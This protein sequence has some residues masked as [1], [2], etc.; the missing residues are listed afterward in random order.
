MRR[1]W[2]SGLAAWALAACGA[3]PGTPSADA[4]DKDATAADAA[5]VPDSA[6][7]SAV[8]LVPRAGESRY[9][10]VGEPVV[11]DGSA[12][13]GAVAF[14]WSFGDGG[15]WDAP[16]PEPTA[17]VA[18]DRP[19][20]YRATLTAFSANG[21]RRTAGVVIT[22]VPG[23]PEWGA[24]PSS[25]ATIRT[26][27][28]P[29][30]S[31]T[32]ALVVPDADQ[33]VLLRRVDDGWAV[34][35]RL[36]TCRGPRTLAA[37]GIAL[38]VAC[39]ADEVRFFAPAGA[40]GAPLGDPATPLNEIRVPMPVGSRPHGIVGAFDG[41]Q[42][43][44]TL[45]ATGEVARV[46]AHAE[47]P[48]RFPVG[49]D[50]RG[51]A[52]LPGERG[53]RLLV[54]RWRSPPEGGEIYVL[55]PATGG[56]ETRR[57][58]FDP[59]VASDTEIGGVPSYLDQVLVAPDGREIALPSLQANIGQ[60][61]FRDGT[62]LRFDTTVR[63]VVS[64][65]DG[66]SLEER[67]DE[68]KQFDERGFASAA[69]YSRHGDYLYVAGLGSRSVDRLDRYDGTPSGSIGDVGYAPAGL[70]LSDDD[71]FLFVDASLS[72]EVVVYDVSSFDRQP[73]PVA[74]LRTI[75][76]E[77]L[78]PAV[79]RGKQLFNDAYDTRLAAAGYVACAHCHL[80]GDGDNLVWDFTDRGEGLRNTI[81]L[82]GRAGA[83]PLHWSANFDEVQDF[84][85]DIR[86]PFGG[87]GL[88]TDPDFHSDSRDMT[89]GAPKAGLSPDLD[90]LAA[91]VAS[92]AE[93][94]PS[95]HPDDDSAARGRA[96]FESPEVGCAGCHA[97]PALTDSAFEAAGVPRLHDVGTLGAG[98]GQRLGG[99]LPGLDTPTLYG[100]WRNP[101][102][103]HDGSAPTLRDVLTTRN[104]AD[105]HGRTSH[106]TPAQLDD[107]VAFLLSLGG[108]VTRP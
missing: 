65:L 47:G 24:G 26:F 11:L 41:V 59:Q 104:A 88:L 105:R 14:Q 36:A 25:S 73:E 39:E 92:L 55:D 54:S 18:Y 42:W 81:A 86:G 87:T 91:Y 49:P 15:G 1:A 77:P 23:A 20:R 38:A 8:P 82:V 7:D 34:S 72:R 57:L 53:G 3:D 60:G 70:A 93:I 74:R 45:G 79:L 75:E 52:W 76:A 33:V 46:G 31:S 89:L 48:D 9:V 50:P 62:P 19:G 95:P 17:T 43:F 10:K 32:V 51:I 96:L 66:A 78:P 13:T 6:A 84:E 64:F 71:R 4:P 58:A 21:A 83:A 61:L 35:R 56:V 28:E 63:A 108:A 30:G 80:D 102:Y 29:D 44:V 98:S 22:A 37:G 5:Q 85:H 99:P 97:G 101:P 2:A 27:R 90:A 16:R 100:L 106:L 68:R 40:G 12:S 107:L 103:L 67:F 94:A 69:V